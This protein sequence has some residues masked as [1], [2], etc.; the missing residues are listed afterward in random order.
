MFAMTLARLEGASAAA[1]A[2]I[3]AERRLEIRLERLEPDLKATIAKLAEW[4]A[5][6]ATLRAMLK[7]RK[8]PDEKLPP[9]PGPVETPIP[10]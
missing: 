6:A 8:V 10:F 4:A 7:E 2:S 1:R 3:D 9:Q 5:Y